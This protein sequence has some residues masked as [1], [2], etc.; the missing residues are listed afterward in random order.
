MN[1]KR[2]FTLV[3]LLVAIAIIAIIAA[4]LF[5]VLSAA[6][7]RAQRTVCMN[8]LRQ[9]GLD[10][11]LYATDFQDSAPKT[12]FTSNS[13]SMYLDGDTAFKEVLETQNI[14][15]LFNCPADTFYFD[16]RT[17]GGDFMPQPL[18]RQPQ[19]EYSS[20][21][22]N[23][24]QMTIFGTNTPGIAGQKLGSIRHPAK[25][26]LVAEMPAYFP[27]SWHEPMGRTPLFNDAKNMVGFV[28]GHVSYIKMFWNTSTPS[29]AALQYDPPP[30]Y[31]YQ[32][33]GD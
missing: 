21:G 28:D 11:H 15:N 1:A 27:W 23:G 17:N 10:I 6:K 25:T 26:V 12:A 2:A 24:G 4:L 8:H 32:W 9:I 7:A 30:G 33:S 31:D 13:A 14:S 5:P 18:N 20:Y 29:D 22:F 3:E 19:S 16:Y